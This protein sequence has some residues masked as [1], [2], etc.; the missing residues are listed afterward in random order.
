MQLVELASE[1][2]DALLE[3]RA[4]LDLHAELPLELDYA[5]RQLARRRG[6]RFGEPSL[7]SAA[8]EDPAS[9]YAAA[10]PAA[11]P[12]PISNTVLNIPASVRERRCAF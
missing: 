4:L 5:P 3:S 2:A 7:G 12:A 8:G 1:L 11:R 10:S 6:R 9:Q